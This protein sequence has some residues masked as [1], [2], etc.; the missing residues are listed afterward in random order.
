MSSFLEYPSARRL[1]VHRTARFTA[2]GRTCADAA[3]HFIKG[4]SLGVLLEDLVGIQALLLDQFIAQVRLLCPQRPRLLVV[5]VI[6]LVIAR[7][8]S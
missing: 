5:L 4:T 3:E 2:Q 6:A 1:V 7:P 8:D